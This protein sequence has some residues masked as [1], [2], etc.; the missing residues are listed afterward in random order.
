MYLSVCKSIAFLL[1][2]RESTLWDKG[3]LHQ[4][5]QMADLLFTLVYTTPYAKGTS[6]KTKKIEVYIYVRHIYRSTEY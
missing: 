3:D 6:Y 4:P 2:Y 5:T 1:K